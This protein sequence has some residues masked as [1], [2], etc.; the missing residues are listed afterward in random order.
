[1][2]A[3][4]KLERLK[5]IIKNYGSCVVAFSGGVDSTFLSKVAFDVLGEKSAAV[6]IVSPMLPKSELDDAVSMA[7]KIGIKHILIEND[8]IEP[9]VVENTKD[10][11]YYCKKV[12][13]G[14]VI[15]AA[16]TFGL[17]YVFDGSNTDDTFDYR[18]GAKAVSELNVKSP[19]KEAG[20]GKKEIREL[21][22][23]MGLKTWNKPAFACLASRIPYGEKIDA[24]KLSRVDKAEEYL[25]SLGFVQF[26][27]RSHG[28]TA[29]IEVA[30]DER[31]K[32]FDIGILDEISDKLKGL[33]YTYVSMELSGYKMGSMNAAIDTGASR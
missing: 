8:E 13:F 17:K 19:L 16:E 2:E 25:K 12:E 23:I 30:R 24:S 18:P 20:M 11:C 32:M 1:M 26:R 5:E 22:H 15:E 27:V 6:T 21:S 28:D 29:R 9:E 33:G 10:R 14:S 7:E 3:K 4:E 31:I